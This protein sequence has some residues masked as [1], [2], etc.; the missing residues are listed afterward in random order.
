MK[1][2]WIDGVSAAGWS[3]AA[4]IV[5]WRLYEFYGDEAILRENYP[6][7]VRYM[8]SVRR[9]TAAQPRNDPR[10]DEHLQYI[11]NNDFQYG[12]WLMPSAVKSGLQGPAMMQ[13]TG[14]EAATLMCVYT[15]TLMERTCRVLGLEAEAEQYAEIAQKIREAF[16]M[17]FANPD[18]TLKKDFQGL[19]VMALAMDAIPA[20]LRQN[21]VDKLAE[22]IHANGDRLD[23]GFL[24]IPFLLPELCRCGQR[25]LANRLLFQ[26][27]EPSWLYEVKM[28]ATTLWESW[29][30]LEPDGNPKPY[31]FNHFAF[32]CVG[33]YLFREIAGIRAEAPGFGRVRIEPDLDCGLS[34]VSA[35]YESIW[36]E[37]SVRWVN[38][39]G[40]RS[41]S[42]TLPPDTAGTLCLDA[43]VRE[44]GCGTTTI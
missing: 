36:G 9:R 13:L 8:D 3:D 42:V 19:Y 1:P 37:I 30:A 28:G 6:A 15:N 32:G 22:L 23:T 35:T 41:V 7:M 12:D 31:S 43:Q 40:M 26:E 5:P 4:V 18:G 17:E 10:T 33:E 27:Q 20:H 2:A 24:S 16:C 21:A 38:R 29:D 44:I 25:T 39:D 14:F 11:W 34:E